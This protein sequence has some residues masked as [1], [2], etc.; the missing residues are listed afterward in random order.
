METFKHLQCELYTCKKSIVNRIYYEY[1]QNSELPNDMFFKTGME[2]LSAQM[3]ASGC[4]AANL[5]PTSY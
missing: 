4:L 3:V 2:E 5:G 1:I